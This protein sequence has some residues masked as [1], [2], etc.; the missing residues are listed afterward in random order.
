MDGLSLAVED[1][2]DDIEITLSDI[3]SILKSVEEGSMSDVSDDVDTEMLNLLGAEENE[4]DRG[5]EIMLGIREDNNGFC[6]SPVMMTSDILAPPTDVITPSKN[7]KR[8][9]AAGGSRKP[10]RPR[11]GRKELPHTSKL[12]YGWKEDGSS[13]TGCVRVQAKGDLVHE[14]WTKEEVKSKLDEMICKWKWT[15]EDAA[16]HSKK[17]VPRWLRRVV[18]THGPSWFRPQDVVI[19]KMDY[20][21]RRHPCEGTAKFYP[22]YDALCCGYEV[23]RCPF[24][25]MSE[26]RNSMRLSP[27][28]V[29][30]LRHR[31]IL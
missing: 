11:K 28:F 14:K 1:R 15:E 26:D 7:K 12:S 24:T 29:D 18:D 25:E 31:N 16:S 20:T 8:P 3:D 19:N 22:P 13:F 2:N 4:Y 30:R 6:S 17:N 9:A 10:K 27:V 21:N 5:I 23:R